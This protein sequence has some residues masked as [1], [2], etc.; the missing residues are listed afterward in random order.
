MSN[1]PQF[2]G[3]QARIDSFVAAAAHV[4]NDG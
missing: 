3:P 1:A 4:L 2:V